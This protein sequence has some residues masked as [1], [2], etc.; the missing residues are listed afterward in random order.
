VFTY[1]HIPLA[2]V[3]TFHSRFVT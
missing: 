2:D 1:Y 3:E